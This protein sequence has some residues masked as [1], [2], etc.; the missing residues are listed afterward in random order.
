VGGQAKVFKRCVQTTT[1]KRS[2]PAHRRHSEVADLLVIGLSWLLR[3][4]Y[5]GGVRLLLQIR[6]FRRAAV[7]LG[8]KD[9][10]TP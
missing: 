10:D 9:W 8:R 4:H 2:Q 6:A 5:S 1:H 3:L 7:P